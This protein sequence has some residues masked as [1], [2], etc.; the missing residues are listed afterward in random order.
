VKSSQAARVQE[1]HAAE[2]PSRIAGRYRVLATL[3]QGAAGAV[4][5]VLDESSGRNFALKQLNL[6]ASARVA[7][8]FEQ[9]YYTLASLRHPHIVEV[10]EYGTDSGV[11]YYTMELLDG[12]DLS[13]LAPLP[14]TTACGYVRDAAA[15]LSVLHARRL[16][17]RDISPRNLW[18]TPE[19]TIKLIDFGAL[20]AFGGARDVVGTPPLVAPEALQGQLLDQRT[21]L[22]ALGA[23][24]YWLVSGVHAYPARHLRDLPSR[25]T[26]GF[27][28]ASKELEARGRADLPPLPG[29]VDA[30][31][32]TLLSQDPRARPSSAGEVYERLSIVAGLPQQHAEGRAGP[33]LPTPVLVGR[34]RERSHFQRAL[35]QSAAGSGKM[36]LI[37]GERGMGRSRVL[38]E[39]ALE[40]RLRGATV[41][42]VQADRCHGQWALGQAL[43]KQALDALP[44]PARKAGKAHAQALA[45]LARELAELSGEFALR[46]SKREQGPVVAG[47]SAALLSQGFVAFMVALSETAPLVLLVD[48]A[49]RLDDESASLLLA[50][51]AGTKDARILLSATLTNTA[52][53]HGSDRIRA[54]RTHAK[55]LPLAALDAAQTRELLQSLFGDVP[56]LP[57]VAEKVFRAT[58]G[59]P[60]RVVSMA[61]QMLARDLVRYVDGSWLLPQ[62][63]PEALLLEDP[64]RE[65]EARLLGLSSDARSLAT[66]LSLH[67]G[68]ATHE[69]VRA[70]SDLAAQ[71]R[72]AALQELSNEGVLVSD[73]DGFSM[74]DARA[75]TL[76]RDE[77]PTAERAR[78]RARLGRY[79]LGTPG[80]S[81]ADELRACV[82]VLAADD[83]RTVSARTT[84][85][86]AQLLFHEPDQL[87]NA[88]APME[89]ALGLF[90]ARGK[91]PYA[92]LRLLSAL[93]V[94]GFFVDRSLSQRYVEDALSALTRTLGLTLAQRLSRF[95][96]KRLAL[97]IGLAVGAF[98]FGRRKKDGQVPPFAEAIRMFFNCNGSQLGLGA[99][100]IDPGAIRRSQQLLAVWTGLG[101]K[102]FTSIIFAFGETMR[103]TISDQPAEACRRWQLLIAQLS[104]KETALGMPEDARIRYLAGA[105]YARGALAAWGEDEGALGYAEQLDALGPQVYKVSA[106]QIRALYYGHRGNLSLFEQYRARVELAAVQYGSAWQ[107]EI[108]GAGAML[109]LYLRTYD[110][111]SMKQTLEQLR[112]LAQSIPSQKPIMLRCHGA[113]LLLR[114]R[115]AE[116]ISV[117]ESCLGDEPLAL[118]GWARTHGSLARALNAQ[119][120]HARALEVCERALSALSPGDLAFHSTNLNL[121]IE[122][123]LSLSGVGRNEEAAQAL[124]ALLAE[125][126]HDAGPL[127]LGAL[128]EGRARVA[129]AVRDVATARRHQAYMERAYRG[130]QIPTLVARC[131]TFARELARA[132]DETAALDEAGGRL[133]GAMLST[134]TSAADVTALE[135]L[136]TSTSSI[137]GGWADNA[138]ELLLG[139]RSEQG[140]IFKLEGSRPALCA[141]STE[142]SVPDEVEAWLTRR[143]NENS[144]VDLTETAALDGALLEDPDAL[145]VDGTFYRAHWLRSSDGGQQETLGVVLTKSARAATPAPRSELLEALTRKLA[146]VGRR[147]SM[148]T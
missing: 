96:G 130:T 3:G 89:E 71:A 39:V 10:Y 120:Q 79:L 129:I 80:L 140:A 62:E 146:V 1:T 69:L 135:R 123:A 57:R 58:Q 110:G 131:E 31:I 73:A 53:T 93:A 145:T 115:Y 136:L 133:S 50:L 36:T 46:P 125:T 127:S 7:A 38:L 128:H 82:H 30:L 118:M 148:E 8:L 52:F 26:R 83:D 141:A 144:S 117:L 139:S 109:G 21:D 103:V 37:A 13:Q 87:R 121:Q 43:V 106:D 40:A 22:Y 59:L 147:S 97:M 105:L 104:S 35:K 102:H 76:L 85:L 111:G 34:E 5:R 45:P 28:P 48:D 132:F 101:S 91:E 78:L 6:D 19:G 107:A 108:W 67:E 29:E 64:H 137:A 119:G 17:H 81:S 24:L 142:W 113:Y 41:L 100:C 11:P 95:L 68:F 90:R 44:E 66:C 124:D 88:I 63:L 84:E 134:E 74:P 33:T 27:A 4:L 20:T 18:L 2:T 47:E 99:L 16:L 61:E 56:H 12:S 60:A 122:H 32:E 75:R 49:E 9:E 51:A 42:F 98:G 92:L 55:K 65:L 25:W 54:L 138:L 94:A 114:R 70:V 126:E 143:A 23:L 15:A 86:A 72:V 14:W 77:L 116:A 112:R